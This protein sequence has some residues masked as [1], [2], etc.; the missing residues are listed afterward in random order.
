[1]FYE[2]DLRELPNNI[3][4]SSA[5][6]FLS[7]GHN[8]WP[9][10]PV[11][12]GLSWPGPALKWSSEFDASNVSSFFLFSSFFFPF[13]VQNCF[14]YSVKI[15]VYFFAQKSLLKY[16]FIYFIIYKKWPW[17]KAK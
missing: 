3:T 17:I 8:R 10:T 11:W 9:Q 15:F 1:M 13:F 2:E 6:L 12:P 7:L 4:T 5:S 16:I 14:F